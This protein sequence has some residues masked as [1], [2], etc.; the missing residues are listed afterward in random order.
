MYYTLQCIPDDTL[1]LNLDGLLIQLQPQVAQKW[2]E[3]GEAAGIPK[4]VLNNYAKHCSPND[5]IVETL[6]Y[7]L[8]NC[9]EQQTWRDVAQVLRKINLQQLARDIEAVYTTGS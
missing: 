4:G 7:W 1:E 5:C 8:R 6:D 2:Y 9:K 3:F